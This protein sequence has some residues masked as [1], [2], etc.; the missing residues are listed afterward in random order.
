[1]GSQLIFCVET[2]KQ[3]KSDWNYINAI[4]KDRY[5]LGTSIKL[6]PVYMNGKMKYRDNAVTHKVKDLKARYP[7][8]SVVIYCID[9]DNWDK[10]E[11]QRKQLELITQY[12]EDNGYELIWFCR[13]IE[14]VFLGEQVQ[15]KRKREESIRFL[16]KHMVKTI[17]EQKMSSNQKNHGNSNILTVL[18]C[19]LEK[20]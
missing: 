19:Y 6:S 17:D 8:E 18:E 12:C 16:K 5:K 10:N 14:E 7:G 13:D 15:D 9:T 1:M 4:I 20:K 11:E 3:N 2:T